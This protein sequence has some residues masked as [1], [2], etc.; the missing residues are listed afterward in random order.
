M[1][2]PSGQPFRPSHVIAAQRGKSPDN[3]RIV[4]DTGEV[5]TDRWSSELDATVF[6]HA[7][8][9]GMR[10][11]DSIA[12]ERDNVPLQLPGWATRENAEIV[13]RA[14]A[15]SGGTRPRAADAY[16]RTLL[17]IG[18]PASIIDAAVIEACFWEALNDG[19]EV[20]LLAGMPDPSHAN[21]S[22]PILDKSP[23]AR[24]AFAFLDMHKPGQ[25]SRL[26]AERITFDIRRLPGNVTNVVT[27]GEDGLDLR[28]MCRSCDNGVKYAHTDAQQP[29]VA[30]HAAMA[31]F[32]CTDCR[33]VGVIALPRMSF[34]HCM[35]N[36][37]LFADWVGWHGNPLIARVD[38]M[39]GEAPGGCR[40]QAERADHRLIA[41]RLAA[42][43]NAN[44]WAAAAERVRA[45]M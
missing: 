37:V 14:V 13:A 9:L 45:Q 11:I 25:A 24:L 27:I 38:G 16:T 33:N 2:T 35:L 4:I 39:G 8:H 7:L 23:L 6:L 10:G 42:H 20:L 28:D 43:F 34:S 12:G 40:Y 3:L 1:A 15:M 29:G 22:D 44:G 30:A 19:R 31:P 17:G 18:E 41:E 5:L 26:A 36:D 21:T 32:P